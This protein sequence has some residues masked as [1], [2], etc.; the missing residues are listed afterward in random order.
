M[1]PLPGP[2]RAAAV[3]RLAWL[4][5]LAA[6]LVTVLALPVVL[7]P[8]LLAKAAVDRFDALPSALVQPPLPQRSVMLAADGSVIATLHG[9]EDRVI[10]PLDQVAKVAQV[11]LV[12]I[13]DSRFY[14]HKG[15]DPRGALRALV[16]NGQAGTVQQGG[17]TL[18]QQYVKNVLLE[19]ATAP[20]DKAAAIADTSARKLREARY[21]LGVEQQLTK[22]QILERYLN[23]A[24]YGNGVYGIGTA[25]QHYF[26]VAAGALTLPQAALLAGL[27]QNPVQYD[28][29]A[30]APAALERR[31]TV[32]DRMLQLGDISQADA[33][34]ARAQPLGVVAVRST[35]A[36]DSCSD[37]TAPFFCAYV[38]D[39]LEN[40]PALGAT[41][42][43]RDTK[44][45]TGG[46]VIRT[47]LDPKVQTAAQKA[48]DSVISTDNRVAAPTVVLQPGTG[49]IVAMAVNRQYGA[50]NGTSATKVLLPTTLEQPGSTAKVWTL[51]AA[52]QLGFGAGLGFNSPACY[53][54]LVF[55]Y[56]SG[57]TSK[58]CP[59]GV[60][61][62]ADSEA[63]FFT[64]PQ[65]TWQSVN[66]YYIQ[67]EERVGVAKVVDAAR[68][69]GV[70]PALLTKVSKDLGSLTIGGLQVSTLD[71]ATAYATLAAHG[72]E[73]DARA[74]AALADSKGAS[75][76][77]TSPP[78]CRQ[79][80]PAAVADTATSILAGVINT[81]GGTG[82]ANASAIG[83]PAA[84]KTGT[85]DNSQAAWFVGYT[86]QLVAAVELS[87]PRGSTRYPLGGLVAAG[88]TWP[89]VF[90]GDVPAMI[91]GRLMNAALA[92]QPVQPLPPP[93][94][95]VAAGSATIPVP[96]LAGMSQTQAAAA[97][98]A[99]GLVTHLGLISVAGKLRPSGPVAT[100][101]P[102]AGTLV[103]AG[104][105]VNIILANG[106]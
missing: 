99:A 48:I 77:H 70:N 84:G 16:R 9:A 46:L 4:C 83:R 76:A 52:L 61:N 35:A 100:T 33:D 6:V 78:P 5:G 7:G 20:A 38:R 2:G 44:L 28:P 65:A 30:H 89:E 53:N 67:L 56:V 82:A 51:V 90:G 101:V 75:V 43:D 80:I 71:Q 36:L 45:Y 10:V 81:P 105:T 22:D 25:A 31:D 104:S 64:L 63:G 39:Q 8:G 93:D 60:T 19:Q 95:V 96:P 32:L 26:G 73:C 41:K 27:V 11:A 92:D 37:A 29:V 68:Q 106:R 3:R 79:T 12:A 18:T 24:Y 40:D 42:A 98:Q 88:R 97:V 91:W 85:T 17:S 21:A 58:T 72:L 54:T 69:L 74:I 66:T 86:P 94:P 59:T 62:A 15:I 87:D 1:P 50:D 14:D 57:N 103:P 13:E 102:A 47:T 34:A 23:I 55:D 49:N